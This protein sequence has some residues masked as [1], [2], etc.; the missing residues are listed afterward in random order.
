MTNQGTTSPADTCDCR[1]PFIFLV[2]AAVFALRQY[3]ALKGTKRVFA[4][5]LL[6]KKER[7]VILAANSSASGT[8]HTGCGSAAEHGR[9]GGT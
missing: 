1:T 5:T 4:H 2:V 6:P 7:E 3:V 8:G 9:L